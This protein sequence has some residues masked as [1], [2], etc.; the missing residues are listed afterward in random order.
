MG[1]SVAIKMV[2]N[3]LMGIVDRFQPKISIL[4]GVDADDLA[5][6]LQVHQPRRLLSTIGIL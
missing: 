5:M 6:K 1:I 4:T 2:M 3:P